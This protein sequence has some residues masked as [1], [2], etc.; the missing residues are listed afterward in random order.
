[1]KLIL[2]ARAESDLG[3]IFRYSKL[4]F[5]KAVAA[6]YVTALNAKMAVVLANPQIGRRFD[7]IDDDMR[8]IACLRHHIYFRALDDALRI[9]RILHQHMDVSR[10]LDRPT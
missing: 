7:A 1:M 4:T 8:R 10:H 3:D 9:V 5:G 6:K 2:S